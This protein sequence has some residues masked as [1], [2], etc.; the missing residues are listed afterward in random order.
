MDRQLWVDAKK[1]LQDLLTE[2]I[3]LREK[4]AVK[5]SSVHRRELGEKVVEYQLQ[6]LQCQYNRGS[7]FGWCTMLHNL[8]KDQYMARRRASGWRCSEVRMK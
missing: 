4:Y 7:T 1:L 3:F 6:Q 5:L 8:K 2:A